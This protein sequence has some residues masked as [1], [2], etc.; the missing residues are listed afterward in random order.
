M[1]EEAKD[2]IDRLLQLESNERLG[3]G[4]PGTD[5]DFHALKWHPFFKGINFTKLNELTVP[6]E[7]KHPE[8][9]MPKQELPTT[10][11]DT[12]TSDDPIV[13][14][15]ELKKKNKYFWNQERHFILLRKG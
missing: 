12:K 6:I 1:S 2:L 8:F 14:Q 3:A 7:K 13:H 4:R 9:E 10:T 11:Q 5:N 15:G